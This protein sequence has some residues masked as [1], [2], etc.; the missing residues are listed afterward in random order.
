M[1]LLEPCCIS[2]SHCHGSSSDCAVSVADRG[3]S[4]DLGLSFAWLGAFR[5]AYGA[6]DCAGDFARDGPAMR[7]LR[8]VGLAL[9]LCGWCGCMRGGAA[10]SLFTIGSAAVATENLQPQ[11]CLFV[12][13]TISGWRGMNL[14]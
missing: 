4:P 3:R 13:G 10:Q 6:V 1:V 14:I 2:R 11:A 5:G 12:L 8:L 9:A 7:S